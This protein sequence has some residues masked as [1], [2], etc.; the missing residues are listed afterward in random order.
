MMVKIACTMRRGRVNWNAIA[1]GESDLSGS[2]KISGA[3]VKSLGCYCSSRGNGVVRLLRVADNQC[4][5]EEC[6]QVR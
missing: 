1:T 4:R 2:R 3:L 6:K 5:V